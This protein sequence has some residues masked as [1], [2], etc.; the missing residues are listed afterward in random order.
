MMQALLGGLPS[1]IYIPTGIVSFKGTKRAVP[2]FTL[3]SPVT[4]ASG[5]V[6]DFNSNVDVT[7]TIIAPS[8]ASFGFNATASVAATAY[9]MGAHWT[10]D[11]D[12]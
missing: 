12:F 2:T 1:G 6:R 3:Y 5:K 7:G 11:A 8:P 4:G 10:A 9:S